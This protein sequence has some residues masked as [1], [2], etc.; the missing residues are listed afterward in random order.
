MS[1]SYTNT[2]R[3]GK[4]SSKLVRILGIGA[5]G[6]AVV[7]T[8][9]AAYKIFVSTGSDETAEE[10]T[11]ATNY[12]SLDELTNREKFITAYLEAQGGIET[13]NSV[14]TMQIVGDV[15]IQGKQG[16]LRL[17]RKRPNLLRISNDYGDRRMTT[18][19]D[20]KEVWQHLSV[21]S[22]P[23]K[24]RTIIGEEKKSWLKHTRFFD[25]IISAYYG[26]G[27]ILDPIEITNYNSKEVLKVTVENS[28]GKVAEIL[29]DPDTMYPIRMQTTSETGAPVENLLRDYIEVSGIHMPSDIVMNIDGELHS[30]TKVTSAKVNTGLLTDI[31]QRPP[32]S[33]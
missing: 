19:F 16:T 12:G 20:G 5:L 24:F 27:R 11:Q 25:W 7:F 10:Y 26:D 30:R 2:K 14:D 1:H 8:I 22:E 21:A 18:A 23:D 4:K 29:V 33:K 15:E 28:Q 3:K 17:Y 32:T 13:L 6:L 31:F 9:A